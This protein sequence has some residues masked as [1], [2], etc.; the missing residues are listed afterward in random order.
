MR[1]LFVTHAFPR[2]SGDVAGAFVLRLALALRAEGVEVHVLAP[3]AAAL[4]ASQE[5]DG[6][7]VTHFRY[8][9]RSWETLAY[10]GTMAEQVQRSLRAKLAMLGMIG[11]GARAVRTCAKRFAPDVV[12]AHWWFPSALASTWSG[13]PIPLVTT[14]HGSDV[15]L[16]LGNQLA[17]R[18]LRRVI[19]KSAAV[20]TVS[21]WLERELRTAV[22]GASAEVAPMPADTGLFTA[23]GARHDA[24]FLFVGR[25]NRQKGIALLLDALGQSASS[26]ELDIVGDGPERANLATMAETMGLSSRVRFHGAIAQPE[27]LPLYRSATALVVP[28]ENEGLGLVAVE[29]Q[30][31][32]TPVIAFRSGGLEDLI[33]HGVTGLLVP[34]G[35]V[36]ALA[37]T[38]RELLG[39]SQ[40]RVEL[41]RAG[42]EAALARF[43]PSQV[44]RQYAALYGR[45]C[46]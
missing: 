12:H 23:G 19:R 27:L 29:A 45:V 7:P 9:P 31:C 43:A 18:G 4:D 10:V 26:A 1:V 11:G 46:S 13:C 44:A 36:R 14:M 3:S 37:A 34:L 15:R 41:G 16:A 25:L 20:T 2:W 42:R 6:V 22:P 28:S 17:L 38:M 39:Y 24:R 30:L 40:R 32:E 5:I 33:V 8:A 21:T 35:D